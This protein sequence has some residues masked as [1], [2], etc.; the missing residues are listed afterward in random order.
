MV[1][2]ACIAFSPIFV[3]L[4]ELEPTATAVHRIA[5]ALPLVWLWM[6]LSPV[7]DEK[8]KPQQAHGLSRYWGFAVAGLFFAGDLVCW[9]W[10]IQFTTVANSTLLANFAPVFVTLAGFFIFGERFSRRFIGGLM[11]A[12]A[13]AIVLMGESLTISAD[14]LFGDALGLAT[15]LFYAGYIVSIGRLRAHYGYSTAEIMLWSGLVTVLVLVVIALLSG[16]ALIPETTYGWLILFGLAWIS[17]AG[18]Q[19]LITYALAHLPA[20]LSS[21]TLLLQPVIAA[22]LA[23]V[24]LAEPIGALQAVGAAII[25]LG[26]ALAR[27]AR[28]SRRTDDA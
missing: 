22:L 12:M 26:I 27:G 15:A 13:G 11:L 16:E 9:H 2:A 14:R 19:S 18:G 24:I 20:A 8:A 1:G 5:L 23:W 4:S 6:A 28:F 10:S 17:Q 3:R 25:I 7:A 21:V